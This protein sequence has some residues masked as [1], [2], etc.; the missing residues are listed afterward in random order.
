M[1]A[2]RNISVLSTDF[3]YTGAGFAKFFKVHGHNIVQLEL[4]HSTGAIEEHYL[5]SSPHSLHSSSSHPSNPNFNLADWCPNLR[6]F[7]CSADAEWNW[8]SPDW[9]A[10]HIL[11]PAHPNV[12]LIAIRD[13]NKRLLDD[14]DLYL[15]RHSNSTA[16]GGFVLPP[17]NHRGPF[18]RLAEQLGSLLR[19]DNFP[20]LRA[21]RDMSWESAVMRKF[22]RMPIPCELLC[23][24]GG[25]VGGGGGGSGIGGIGGGGGYDVWDV[26]SGSV[27]RE[28]I[29]FGKALIGFWRIVKE[30]CEPRGVVLQD[31]MGEPVHVGVV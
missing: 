28:E 31:W 17:S 14:L 21:V 29:E 2:L 16:G 25:S 27:R 10:P 1:P 24:A 13:M 8:Q 23:S 19:S 9:I 12:Q 5:T 4:G 18:F 30:T 6:E 26:L 11:L 15:V 3:S 20:N 22:K 7:I